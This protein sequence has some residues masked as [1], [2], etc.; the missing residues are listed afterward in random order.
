MAITTK[1]KINGDKLRAE[2]FRKG[3]TLREA[4]NKLGF[5]DTYISHILAA[6]E[7]AEN[8]ATIIET[9]LGIKPE[10]YVLAEPDRAEPAQ[11]VE[12]V[13]EEKQLEIE[14]RNIE[15]HI[16]G[17][18]VRDIDVEYIKFKARELGMQLKSLCDVMG[19]RDNYLYNLRTNGATREDFERLLMV[20]R[21]DKDDTRIFRKRQTIKEAEPETVEAI[22]TKLHKQESKLADLYGKVK[23]LKE[24]NEELKEENEELKRQLEGQKRLASAIVGSLARC[25]IQ[26]DS[27]KKGGAE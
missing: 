6:E 24:E 3:Y 4:S 16:D 14:T 7:I 27:N 18:M 10:K 1:V 26:V 20:L 21:I 8:R 11:P 23:E 25:G 19:K 2:L 13:L 15:D 17:G 12:I 9:I 5:N 22:E